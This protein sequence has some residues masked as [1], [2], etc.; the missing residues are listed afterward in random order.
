MLFEILKRCLNLNRL[1]KVC[2]ILIDMSYVFSLR[3]TGELVNY[4][5]VL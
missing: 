3:H 5:I 2:N 1:R 4:T